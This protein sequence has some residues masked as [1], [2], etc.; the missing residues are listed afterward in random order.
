MREFAEGRLLK[1]PDFGL[2]RKLDN[3]ASLDGRFLLLI[4]TDIGTEPNSLNGNVQR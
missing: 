4:Y 3:V 2:P 1:A